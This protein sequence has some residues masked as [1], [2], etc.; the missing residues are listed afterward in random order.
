MAFCPLCRKKGRAVKP[1]TIESLVKET[2]RTRLTRADG[3]EFCAGQSCDTVYF[4][5]QSGERILCSEVKVRI[6][7]KET[8]PPRPVCYCFG[9]TVEEIEEEAAKTGTSRVPESIAEQC[10]Q[11]FAR[12]EET[13]PQGA[14]CLGNVQKALRS[15]QVR[16]G[17]RISSRPR[18]TVNVGTAIP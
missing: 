17:A 18:S 1:V 3:F 10:R 9:H 8:C 15:A 6:G 5:P 14:C 4:H 7:Q 2:A 12:C 13:N 11:G 16:Y